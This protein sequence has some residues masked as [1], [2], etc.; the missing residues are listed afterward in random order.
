MAA[1]VAHEIRNPLGIMKGANSIIQKKYGS[2]N[3]EVFTYIPAELHRLNK[4]IEDFLAFA[5]TREISIQSVNLRDMMTKLQVGFSEQINIQFK[6]EIPEDFPSLNTDGDL[7]E[8]ILLNIIKNSVQTCSQGGKINIKCEQGVKNRIKIQI[9]DNG[10]G[11]AAEIIDRIFDPFFTTKDE[12]SGLGLAISKRLLEQLDGEIFVRSN[13]GK[14]TT[15][16]LSLPN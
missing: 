6:F 8:Q 2:N 1:S 3:D 11:I 9:T 12:G 14:G 7:L 16:T 10:P 13:P 4:L 15:V 5:R